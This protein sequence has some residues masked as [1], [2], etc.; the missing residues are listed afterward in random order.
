[1]PLGLP[2]APPCN[3][4]TFTL[5]DCYARRIVSVSAQTEQPVRAQACA[6]KYFFH[7]EDGACIRD[8][9]GT[10]FPDDASAMLEAEKVAQELSK[11]PVH[12]YEWRAV[13]KSAD[14]LRVGS[15]PLVPGLAAKDVLIPPTS[16][17]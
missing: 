4:Q 15:V 1:M 9:K 11:L 17:H 10:V 14:G 12:A 13:V 7:L 8:P 2:F 5:P 6:M 3:R 16:I